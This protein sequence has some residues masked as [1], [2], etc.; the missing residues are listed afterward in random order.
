MHYIFNVDD[1]RRIFSGKNAVIKAI[2]KK[3]NVTFVSLQD[4]STSFVYTAP[5]IL[6]L[7]NYLKKVSCKSTFKV[8]KVSSGFVNRGVLVEELLK[9]SLDY[10]QGKPFLLSYEKSLQG[11]S[12]Y[13][14]SF[15]NAK[16]LGIALNDNG[17]VEIKYSNTNTGANH[18]SNAHKLKY[19]LMVV[20]SG[21]YNV[22][23][24]P[25][26]YENKPISYNRVYDSTSE[27]IDILSKVLGF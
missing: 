4:K 25:K 5:T 7:V 23:V 18:L 1:L 27:R 19:M 16:K 11:L 26:D 3:G 12:D 21:V 10:L 9:A 13:T 8:E 24:S 14:L 17:E 20:P 2:D 22:L 15:E 6:T